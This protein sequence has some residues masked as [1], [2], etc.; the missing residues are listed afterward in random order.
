MA[1]VANFL[2]DGSFI[3]HKLGSPREA[4]RE[5]EYTLDKE[6]SGRNSEVSH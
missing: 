6:R 4:P 2:N 3:D 1:E 5:V